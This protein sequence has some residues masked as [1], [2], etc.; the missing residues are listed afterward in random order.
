MKSRIYQVVNEETGKVVKRT[1]SASAAI[2]KA[3]KIHHGKRGLIE[4]KVTVDDGVYYDPNA[5]SETEGFMMGDCIDARGEIPEEDL[6][7]EEETED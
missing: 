5:L 3:N 4:T 6:F 2:K 7:V 1:S